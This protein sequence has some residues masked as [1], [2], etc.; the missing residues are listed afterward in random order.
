MVTND[1]VM[2]N[3]VSEGGFLRVHLPMNV[4]TRAAV[5]VLPSSWE[6]AVPA[7]LAAAWLAASWP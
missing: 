5:H 2:G 1:S 7:V 3:R 4:W 6:T